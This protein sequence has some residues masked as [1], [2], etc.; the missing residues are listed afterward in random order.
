MEP[1]TNLRSHFAQ[2]VRQALGIRSPA[3]IE[4]LATVPREAFM[5]PPPWHVI[6]ME[7]FAR[8]YQVTADPRD[9]Y[10]NVVVGLDAGR[11]LN[12]GSPLAVVLLLD[13]LE[14]APGERFLHIGCGTGY[15]SALAAHA[16]GPGG[17]VVAVEIDPQLAAR[18]R[19]NL[20]GHPTV[21]VHQGDGAAGQ[22]GIFD[23][24]FVNAGCTRVPLVWL[25]QLA[26]G[27]RLLLPLTVSDPVRPTLGTGG[28]LLVRRDADGCPARFILPV[29]IFHCASARDPQEELLL[30]RANIARCGIVARLRHDEHSQAAECWLHGP[31][32]CLQGAV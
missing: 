18:A 13:A 20:H 29:N 31:G 9:L 21:T 25:R 15:Y 10:R 4:G 8:G 26:P 19:E 11:M 6:R 24:I 14:L 32:W 30:S 16:V 27:G 17:A 23:A 7:E 28:M 3:L 2:A 12:N 22:L 1:L 5:G